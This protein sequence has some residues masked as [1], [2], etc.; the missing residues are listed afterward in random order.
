[1]RVVENVHIARPAADVWSVVADLDTHPEWRPAVVEFRQVSE[2]PLGVGTRIREVLRWRGREIVIDDTVTVFEPPHRLGLRGGWKAADF[3][4]DFR[5]DPSA[6][7]TDVTM[8][9][10][11]YPKSVLMKVAAPFLGGA[12]RR[13][14][15]EELELLK[16]YVEQRPQATTPE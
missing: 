16:D 6:E 8:E 12:M 5:L 1:M 3:E 9:W 15:K 14:T 13:S 4:V 7:G 10:P 2:A 11:L